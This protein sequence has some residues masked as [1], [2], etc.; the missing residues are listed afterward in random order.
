MSTLDEIETALGVLAFGYTND[1]TTPPSVEAFRKSFQSDAGQAALKRNI[2][3]LHCTTE[4]PAPYADV[5]LMAMETMRSRFGLPVGYS[6]HTEGIEVS[7]A[8]A[9]LGAVMIEKHFTLDRNLPGPDHKASVEPRE[10]EQLVRAVRNV[11]ASLGSP[12]KKVAASEQKNIVIAR[13]SLVAAREI[14]KGELFSEDNLTTKR[15]G[16][17]LDPMRFWELL[18]RPADRDY[19]EDDEIQ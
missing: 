11:D 16:S 19:R 2:T 17:G 8:A 1:A 13:K 10:L 14:G 3:L 5:N 9:A 12:E 7:V 4:Y 15:P 18:G 6:D